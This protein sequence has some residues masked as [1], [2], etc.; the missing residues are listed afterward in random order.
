MKTIEY[1]LQHFTQV[2]FNILRKNVERS[3]SCFGFEFDQLINSSYWVVSNDLPQLFKKGEFTNAL[4]LLLEDKGEDI[5]ISKL[6]NL[7]KEDFLK[8]MQFVFWVVDE[9]ENIKDLEEQYLGGNPNV[10]LLQAG[11]SE[12]NMLGEFVSL[13]NLAMGDLT[14][15]E[16]I[17]KMPYN[18]VFAKK[19]LQ[20]R[21]AD[22]QERLR[23]ILKNKQKAK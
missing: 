16:E 6:D 9:L 19:L 3:N 12:L 22:I 14:K 23:D 21:T 10:D 17:K 1:Y 20:K 4:K 7:S 11:I 15:Y 18:E 13:D 2:D 8:V 5:L